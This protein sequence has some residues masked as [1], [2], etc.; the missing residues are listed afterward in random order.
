MPDTNI[1]F[2]DDSLQVLLQMPSR[3][4]WCAKVA[5]HNIR[6]GIYYLPIRFCLPYSNYTFGTKV[7]HCPPCL[8]HPC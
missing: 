6:D 1:N 7:V 3:M 4:L 5:H 8:P 2:V